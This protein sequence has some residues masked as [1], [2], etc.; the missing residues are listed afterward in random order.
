MVPAG[1]LTPRVCR[2]AVCARGAA[3]VPPC[4]VLPAVLPRFC[5]CTYTRA[6]ESGWYSWPPGCSTGGLTGARYVACVP[7]LCEQA[8][9]ATRSGC[10]VSGC[11][12]V[13]SDWSLGAKGPG[14]RTISLP[15]R[16]LPPCFNAPPPLSGL[17]V[18]NRA[19]PVT[20]HWP[21]AYAPRWALTPDCSVGPTGPGW[22]Q[23]GVGG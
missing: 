15:F 9:G 12:G 16:L 19:T 23:F 5:V 7:V 21:G 18:P 11:A 14:L 20:R 10:S 2:S 4:V 6:L 8:W 3:Y 13:G 1:W 17:G 22:C